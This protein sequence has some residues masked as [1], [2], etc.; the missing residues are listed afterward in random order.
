MVEKDEISTGKYSPIAFSARVQRS[1][2][3]HVSEASFP[4]A[5]E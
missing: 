5:V 1:G 4:K 3:N 2:Q